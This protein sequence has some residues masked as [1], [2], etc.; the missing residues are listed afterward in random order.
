MKNG[1]PCILR[2]ESRHKSKNHFYHGETS[3]SDDHPTGHNTSAVI[4]RM[5]MS[6]PVVK[7]QLRRQGHLIT[8]K[9]RAVCTSCNNG[10]MSQ[11][12]ERAKPLLLPGLTGNDVSLSPADQQILSEW[13]F[14][15]AL[16]CEHSAKGLALTPAED[17]IAFH[18]S[19]KVPDYFR[20]Y[21]GTHSTES[22]TWLLRYSCTISFSPTIQPPLLD[23][24]QRNAQTITFVVGSLLFH[25]LSARVANFRFDTD[26]S[27]P[28]LAQL[29]TTAVGISLRTTVMRKLN[30][31][32][33]LTLTMSLENFLLSKRPRFIE[34]V[35]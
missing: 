23:G 27:Y 26:I 13:A 22:I 11:L 10:W 7:D 12:E 4:S 5:G 28:A 29:A 30:E 17:R 20:I 6:P 19:R 21:V 18:K 14:A 32:E 16:I 25:V 35:I 34:A 24:L 8:K 1:K 2:G 31:Q 3:L 15:K 33:I 9:I